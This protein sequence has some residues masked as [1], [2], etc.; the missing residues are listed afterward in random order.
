MFQEVRRYRVRAHWPAYLKSPSTKRPDFA[1]LLPLQQEPHPPHLPPLTPGPRGKNPGP[2]L[3]QHPARPPTTGLTR[4]LARP[5]PR[6]ASG[7]ERGTTTPEMP[8]APPGPSAP[9][10]LIGCAAG[11]GWG[12]DR[13]GAVCTCAR[14]AAGW[15]FS[16]PSRRS[17]RRRGFGGGRRA[18][19][20]GSG[21]AARV[22]DTLWMPRR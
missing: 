21:A 9:P 2:N 12:T 17:A 20:W 19:R 11:A 13:A 7:H 15:L 3:P 18:S 16:A 10:P 4:R 1:C 14:R 5:A 8:R 22:E 6:R